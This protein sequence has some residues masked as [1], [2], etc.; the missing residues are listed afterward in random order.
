MRILL[1]EDD[2]IFAVIIE[3]FLVN[4]QCEITVSSDLQAAK[5]QLMLSSFDFILLDNQLSDGEGIDI[6]PFIKSLSYKLPVMMITAADN[7]VL[8]SEAFEK[9]VDDFLMKPI[10]VDLLWQK[11]QRCLNLYD[12]AAVVELQTKK[13]E[14]L[15][16]QREQEES[17]ARYVYE[18]IATSLTTNTQ[19]VDTYIQASSSFNGDIFICKAAPN[20]NIFVMLAD[21]TGHGLAAAISILPLAS[22]MKA[23]IKK[24]LPLAHLI[25]EANKKLNIELPDNKF[26]ALIGIEINFN[27]QEL[28][29]FNGGMPDVV[30][31]KKDKSLALC[32][33]TSMALGILESEAFDPKIVTLDIAPIQN[34]FFFSDGLIEQTDPGG[35]PF[36]MHRLL[37]ILARYNYEEPLVTC[38]MNEFT[39][40]NKMAELLDDLSM[41]D[42]Q[43]K[44]LMDNHVYQDQAVIA[45]DQGKITVTLEI[46]GSLLI[47]TDIVGCLDSIMR[48]TDMIGD[49]RQR[50][51]TVFAELI[52]NGVE[53]GILDLDSKLKNNSSGFAEYLRLKEDR[54][55]NIGADDKLSMTFSFSPSTAEINFEIIDSGQGFDINKDIDVAVDAL[56]G[57]GMDLIKKLCKKVE[58]IAPGNKTIVNLKR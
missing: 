36:G 58:I 31:L 42:L 21:A 26:V 20:G 24:G 5:E 13:L 41:C 53:H 4:K 57:R 12:K 16:E 54:L 45:S 37:E 3:S 28:Q 30:L 40:F 2:Y 7:Q 19:Y 15:L 47:S 29:L 50:A 34:L 22:T 56:S 48:N 14:K 10:S 46:Q 52:S 11:I 23:M 6:L 43:L 32:A 39:I 25:H 38:V 33:S 55:V 51:L 44:S 18:D 9:G 35:K 49:L 17:L 27:K 1:I 8:M